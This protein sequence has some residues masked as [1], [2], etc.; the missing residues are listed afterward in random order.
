ML[1]RLKH[2]VHTETSSLPSRPNFERAL[3]RLST[4][5]HERYLQYEATIETWTRAGF[6]PSSTYHGKDVLDLECGDG[7][8]AAI[9]R[10][11]GAKRV[12]GIDTFLDLTDP[13]PL[14]RTLP[15]VSFLHGSVRELG[16]ELAGGF[17]LV[18]CQNVTEHVPDLAVTFDAAAEILR[19]AGHLF[20]NHDNYYQPTGHHDHGF[21]FLNIET[22]RVE[23]QG[24]QCWESPEK[25][26]VSVE[27]RARLRH[28]WPTLWDERSEAALS[29]HNCR[30]CPY[31]KRSQP[32][33]HLLFADE[34]TTV[35][36]Q[37][38][39]KAAG[40]HGALNKATLFQVRQFI[41]EAGLSIERDGCY[42]VK[43]EIP[44]PLRRAFTESDLL[45]LQLT[46][47]ARKPA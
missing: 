4:A 23:A 1:H 39:F 15:D 25:C 28:R 38:F 8:A 34:F 35:F 30:A 45:A 22:G 13:P 21:L 5:N 14:F 3:K 46:L 11:L 37:E 42:E 18:F 43:N 9:L 31:W 26:A 10:L 29:P 40:P 19:P 16:G 6:L 33:A 12:V 7:T 17:D 41:R 27:H 24:V 20:L 2:L 36:P 32:W 44:E 47:L